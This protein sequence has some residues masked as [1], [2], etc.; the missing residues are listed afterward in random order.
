MLSVSDFLKSFSI[1]LSVNHALRRVSVLRLVIPFGD[2]ASLSFVGHTWHHER[3]RRRLGQLW[4]IIQLVYVSVDTAAL[5]E[6]TD[7]TSQSFDPSRLEVPV[8]LK[9]WEGSLR[10][11]ACSSLVYSVHGAF[12]TTS[13]ITTTNNTI[14]TVMRSQ[15]S[16]TLFGAIS[17]VSNDATQLVLLSTMPLRDLRDC[18]TQHKALE[19]S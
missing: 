3:Q 19:G 13:T 6:G 15:T 1:P 16:S 2:E 5:P 8:V 9:Y 7:P 18:S 10:S 4:V 12:R 14:Y 11:V 17:F